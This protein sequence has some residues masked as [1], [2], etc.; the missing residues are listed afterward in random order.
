MCQF[1]LSICF[2]ECVKYEDE[3][4]TSP[5]IVT[6]QRGGRQRRHCPILDRCTNNFLLISTN[7]DSGV[8]PPTLLVGTGAIVPGVKR[9]VFEADNLR[10]EQ[11]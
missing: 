9:P 4:N 7:P 3:L 11:G 10:L 1:V 2:R 6:R 8:P 5:G